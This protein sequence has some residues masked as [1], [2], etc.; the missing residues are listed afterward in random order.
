MGHDQIIGDG[1]DVHAAEGSGCAADRYRRGRSRRVG[2][3]V[4]HHRLLNRHFGTRAAGPVSMSTALGQDTWS[5]AMI[6]ATSSSLGVGEIS[7]TFI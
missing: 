6:A 2:N 7:K 3:G 1:G 5:A 4:I